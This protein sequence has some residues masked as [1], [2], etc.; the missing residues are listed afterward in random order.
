MVDAGLLLAFTLA[1]VFVLMMP[2]PTVLTVVSYG[3]R[4]GP[5]AAGASTAG[6]VLGDGLAV[7]LCLTGA[8]AVLAV[9]PL[10]FEIIKWCGVAYLLWLAF[11]IWRTSNAPDAAL[12]LD[13]RTAPGLHPG[14]DATH[15]AAD[16][17]A[18]TDLAKV[19]RQTFLVTTLNPKGIAF[20]L[21]F[22]P[23][24]VAAD[25]PYWGQVTVY[26]LLFVGLGGL[27]ALAYA[28]LSGRLA[29]VF[30]RPGPVRILRRVSAGFLLFAALI[31]AAGHVPTL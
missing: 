20:F 6:V 17:A 4:L 7:T 21:A 18:Q 26:G 25:R 14:A 15:A 10:A 11:G 27:N 30:D 19:F 31:T 1:A 13:L 12:N 2:G 3:L 23:Q 22:I 16:R 5:R 9:S 29:F 28:Y 8:G 24:F